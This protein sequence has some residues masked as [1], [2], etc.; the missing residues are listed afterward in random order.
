MTRGL[1][2]YRHVDIV[3]DDFLQPSYP[4]HRYVAVLVGITGLAFI[5]SL[6][7][8]ILMYLWFGQP[9]CKLNQ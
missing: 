2:F 8:V 9:P 7:A 1:L 5:G 4:F 6:V 3:T